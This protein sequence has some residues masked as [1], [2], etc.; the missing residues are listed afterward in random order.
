MEKG[1][2][3]EQGQTGRIL[4]DPEHPYTRKL[5]DAVPHTSKPE[6]FRFSNKSAPV[7]LNASKIRVSFSLGGRPFTA[8]DKVSFQVRQGEVLGIVGESGSGKTTLSNAIVRLVSMDTGKVFIDDVPFHELGGA[9]LRPYRKQVQMVFQDPYASLDPRMTVHDIIAEPLQLHGLTQGSR[10]TSAAVSDMMQRVGLM[11]EWAN[12]YPHEFSG[13]QCQRVAIARALAVQ[14]KLLIADEP[15]SALDV[16]IQ[17]QILDLL[18]EL[19]ARNG[20]SMIFVSHDLA[21]VRYVAD[22]VAVMHNGRMIE[23]GD[24]ESLYENPQQNY[25]RELVQ[26]GMVN[27]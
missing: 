13:G 22:R 9:S 23:Q 1:V 18:L 3:V 12:K 25:T 2:A 26:L 10:E 27:N 24:T 5:L 11:P 15:V 16:T 8:V 19:V 7:C 21:V 6:A 17:A 14:P 20:L 4:N